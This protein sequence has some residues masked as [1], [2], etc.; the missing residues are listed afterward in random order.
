VSLE[1]LQALETPTPLAGSLDEINHL[2]PEFARHVSLAVEGMKGSVALFKKAWQQIIMEVA[3]GDT[4]EMHA[5][6][7]KVVNAFEKRLQLLKETHTLA[8]WLRDLGRTEVP[9]PGGLLP[10]IHGMETLKARVFDCWHTTDD[11]EEL[12]AR[13]YPLT[14]ADF[15]RAASIGTLRRPPASWYAE[16]DKPSDRRPACLDFA[17]DESSGWN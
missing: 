1:V 4:A 11:L 16:E 8:I 12:A 2:L 3:K 6:R 9:D 15:D 17:V 13:D 14:N 7:Q 10:E 5:I